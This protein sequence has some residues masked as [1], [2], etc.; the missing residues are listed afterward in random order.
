[1]NDAHPV[2]VLQSHACL[3]NN[4]DDL[5]L[6]ESDLRAFILKRSE[7]AQWVVLHDY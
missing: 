6:S 5:K 4:L 3:G 7:I 2:N 1:M